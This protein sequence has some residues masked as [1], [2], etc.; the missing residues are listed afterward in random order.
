MTKF[1]LERARC[2]GADRIYGWPVERMKPAPPSYLLRAVDG[3]GRIYFERELREEK[4]YDAVRYW[5]ELTGPI[6]GCSPSKVAA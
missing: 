4:Y 3:N 5:M 6:Q 1:L 2:A